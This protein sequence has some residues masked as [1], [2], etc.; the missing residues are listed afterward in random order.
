MRLIQAAMIVLLCAPSLLSRQG[1]AAADAQ[2]RG[3]LSGTV[4]DA[5]GAVIPNA[6]IRIEHWMLDRAG[7]GRWLLHEDALI[8]TNGAGGLSVS[9]PPG[10]YE[11]FVSYVGM[12]PLAKN[13]DIK[14]GNTT[15][16]KANLRFGP[17]TKLIE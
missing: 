12:V 6:A 7:Q 9:L 16:L 2:S 17:H 13:V 10:T 15:K 1:V 3:N 4:I 14:E 11:V 5:S 8:T